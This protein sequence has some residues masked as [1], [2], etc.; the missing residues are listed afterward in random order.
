MKV[1]LFADFKEAAGGHSE[2]YLKM[3]KTITLRRLIGEMIDRFGEKFREKILRS[4]DELREDV[5]V[6]VNRKRIISLDTKIDDEDEVA[7]L[8]PASGG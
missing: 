7:F 4:N 2:V 6:L 3:A 5:M 1:R 8:P